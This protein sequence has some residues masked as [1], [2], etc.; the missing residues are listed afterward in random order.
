MVGIIRTVGVVALGLAG[1]GVAI[2]EFQAFAGPLGT[3]RAAFFE[4]L[5]GEQPIETFEGF[6]GGAVVEEMSSIGLRFLPEDAD[7][8]ELPLPVTVTNSPVSSP[9]WMANF[10][11]G[12]PFWSAWVIAPEDDEGRIYAFGQ[13]N[14]QGDWVLV[15][16][17]DECGG[18][19]GEVEAP[20]ITAF[21]GFISSEP[22]YRVHVIPLGNGDG[23]N[24]MDDLT[25][26]LTAVPDG[27]VYSGDTN[28]DNTVT[29]VDLNNVLAEFGC[30]EGCCADLD[31]DGDVDS[32]DL[33]LVLA[34][35]GGSCG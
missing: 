7:G 11:N 8:S 10:G 26:S 19:I 2:A 20:P 3:T 12:R 33:N 9:Q 27:V 35:F 23:A 22:V 31:D 34:S 16:A 1:S 18:L 15:R 14:S 28:D 13:A 30:A 24:G 5:G 25:A 32:A 17:Y 6:G 4:A 29:S 21:A